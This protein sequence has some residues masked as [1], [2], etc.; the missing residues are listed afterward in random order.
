MIKN[1]NYTRFIAFI[2]W[3]HFVEKFN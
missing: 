1:V 2:G 3:Q